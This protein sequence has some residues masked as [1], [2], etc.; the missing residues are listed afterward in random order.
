MPSYFLNRMWV[1]GKSGKSHLWREVVPFWALA[2]FGLVFSTLAADLG[3]SF[4]Q[5]RH[6]SPFGPTRVVN[7]F[8]LGSYAVTWVGKFVLFHKVLFVHHR[9]PEPH[10]QPVG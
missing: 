8:S 7:L 10:V 9:D 6:M 2:F 3:E 5:G 4:A 1:W